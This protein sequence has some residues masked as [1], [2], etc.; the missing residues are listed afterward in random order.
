MAKQVIHVNK[1]TIQSNAKHGDRLP[2]LTLRRGRNKVVAR[3]QEILIQTDPPVIVRYEPEEPL[4]CGARV[5]IET[6]APIGVRNLG[7][8]AFQPA[9]DDATEVPRADVCSD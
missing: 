6:D 9:T 3:A 2:P 4:S 1:N 8:T 5:W 7:Q